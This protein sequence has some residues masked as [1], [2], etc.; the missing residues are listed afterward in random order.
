MKRKL[1]ISV[2]AFTKIAAQEFALPEILS[3]GTRLLLDVYTRTVMLLRLEGGNAPLLYSCQLTPS[4]AR[5][6]LALLQAYPQYCPYQDLF[7]TLYPASQ[8]APS[9]LCDQAWDLRPI[10]RALVTL[11]P[12][13]RAFGLEAVSLRGRGYVLAPAA[14][15]SKTSF[16]TP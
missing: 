7:A 13:L 3:D 9:C 10:R 14:P 5:I 15:F 4:A 16:P 2:P 1:P 6:F 12:V 8:E 11:A